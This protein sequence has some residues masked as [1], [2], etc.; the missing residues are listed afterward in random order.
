MFEAV[1][2]TIF[3]RGPRVDGELINDVEREKDGEGE[4][5]DGDDENDDEDDEFAAPAYYAAEWRRTARCYDMLEILITATSSAEPLP[6]ARSDAPP[7]PSATD[8][9]HWKASAFDRAF[10]TQLM[11]M[12]RSADIRERDVAMKILHALY[13]NVRHARSSIEKH[14][15][16][17]LLTVVYGGFIQ[18]AQPRPQTGLLMDLHPGVAHMLTVLSSILAGLKEI[19]PEKEKLL[20]GVLLPLHS[21]PTIGD[22]HGSLCMCI[23]HYIALDD[24]ARMY[25]IAVVDALLMYWPKSEV[26]KQHLFLD[27]LEDLCNAMPFQ[28][29]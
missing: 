17:E 25:C 3:A 16:N 11:Q 9:A 26:S 20:Y 4:T 15:T 8:L 10:V 7:R 19:R 28:F 27:E 18:C 22:F 5:A 6:A 12:F 29:V 24:P 21:A 2:S 1:S 14:M 23:S 13:G